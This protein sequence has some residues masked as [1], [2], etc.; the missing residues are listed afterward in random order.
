MNKKILD[1]ITSIG[2]TFALS[3]TLGLAA[4][5]KKSNNYI[6][7]TEVFSDENTD[8][9]DDAFEQKTTNSENQIEK[10]EKLEKSIELIKKIKD[11]DFKDIY[12]NTVINI[13][14]EEVDKI[15]LDEIERQY[16][17]Y[18]TLSKEKISNT[19]YQK[20]ERLFIAKKELYKSYALLNTQINNYGYTTLYEFGKNLYKTIILDTANLN[21][22][23]TNVTA[24]INQY[25]G[26]GEYAHN[27][28]YTSDSGYQTVIDIDPNS[29]LFLLIEKVSEY[30]DYKEVS[31]F[32]IE[33]AYDEMTVKKIEETLNLYKECIYTKYEIN[34][35]SFLFLKEPEEIISKETK[36]PTK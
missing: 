2:I 11:I 16:K 28:T 26:G 10:I 34:D 4:C 22:N 13:T 33:L 36:V 29:K 15:D 30:E 17:E 21:G 32:H 23:E 9:I 35:K 20:Q 18:Q 7:M 14:K 5:A 1:K 25:K 12:N 19:D 6:P 24:L 27:A 8:G 31:D 3:S